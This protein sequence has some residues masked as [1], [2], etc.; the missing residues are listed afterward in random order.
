MLNEL[1]GKNTL[2]KIDNNVINYKK[3]SSSPEIKMENKTTPNMKI[4]G[5]MN[6]DNPSENDMVIR[7]KNRQETVPNEPESKGCCKVF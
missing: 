3:I 5:E 2:P 4:Q 1:N 6:L 7:N